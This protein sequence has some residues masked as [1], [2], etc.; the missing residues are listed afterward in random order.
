MFYIDNGDEIVETSLKPATE[1]W[2]TTEQ[3]AEILC[4]C[5]TNFQTQFRPINNYYLVRNIFRGER[6]TQSARGQ[7]RLWWIGDLFLIK[8][9]R[10]TLQ[11]NMKSA[12]HIF[13][14]LRRGELQQLIENRLEF[15]EYC[16]EQNND[17]VRPHS[18]G[19]Q[20]T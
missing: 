11:V 1:K 13:R 5:R 2:V 8:N 16:Y 14:A 20:G 3:A 19:T 9:I 7:G 18:T 12:C 15:E 10:A 6:S 17:E 4:M